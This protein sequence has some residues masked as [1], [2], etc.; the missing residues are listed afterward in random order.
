[1]FEDVDVTCPS[2]WEP[3][4]LEVDLLVETQDYIE[5][6]P[7]CCQPMQV[8]CRCDAGELVSVSVEPAG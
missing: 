8:I 2:C 7:V 4:T 3:I 6:C 1:M 5:D